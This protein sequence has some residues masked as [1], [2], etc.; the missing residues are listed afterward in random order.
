V[1]ETAFGRVYCQDV[2]FLPPVGTIPAASACPPELGPFSLLAE[3][4]WLK[5]FEDQQTKRPPEGG[6]LSG[7]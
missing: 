5:E 2:P 4:R 3:S 1:T 7:D 6:F